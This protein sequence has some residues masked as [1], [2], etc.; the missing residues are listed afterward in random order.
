[1]IQCS[2]C[3]TVTQY[4]SQTEGL[5]STLREKTTR[6]Q[7]LEESLERLN[8]QLMTERVRRPVQQVA[9]HDRQQ[10]EEAR[11]VLEEQLQH[12]LEVHQRQVAALR[13]EIANKECLVSQM[14]Q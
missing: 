3:I 11:R 8:E 13:A 4:E 7:E 9:E 10:E 1:M 2:D 12:Q 5:Q 6:Q 14:Q